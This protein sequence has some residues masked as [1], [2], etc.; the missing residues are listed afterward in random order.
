MGIRNSGLYTI[1]TKEIYL[2]SLNLYIFMIIN[3]TRSGIDDTPSGSS[4]WYRSLPGTENATSQSL[5]EAFEVVELMAVE[6]AGLTEPEMR[7]IVERL[8]Q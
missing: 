1:F 8:R 4:L 2:V 5:R 7:Y 3:A 6:Y